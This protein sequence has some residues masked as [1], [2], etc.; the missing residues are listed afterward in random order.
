[1]GSEASVYP[2]WREMHN[3]GVDTEKLEVCS[4]SLTLP[5]KIIRKGGRL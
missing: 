5:V 4:G 1:M 3:K 2:K